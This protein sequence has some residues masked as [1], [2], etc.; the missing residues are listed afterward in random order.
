MVADA[1]Q[2]L[3][4]MEQ[5]LVEIEAHS[6]TA[7][8]LH[9]RK[10]CSRIR[11]GQ[12]RQLRCPVC[13]GRQAKPERPRRSSHVVRINDDNFVLLDEVQKIAPLPSH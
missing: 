9:S 2:A 6:A 13:V 11:Y 10:V 4:E 8:E 7:Q 3:A 1:R 12:V 5:L